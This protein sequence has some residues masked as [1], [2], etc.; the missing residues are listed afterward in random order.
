ME[1]LTKDAPL[2]AVPPARWHRQMTEEEGLHE[3]SIL[4]KRSRE[5]LQQLWAN[6]IGKPAAPGLRRE[7]LVRILEYKIREQVY[8]GLRPHIRARLREI[9]E[10]L[11]KEKPIKVA[12][13]RF[14][15]GTRLLRFQLSASSD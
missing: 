13:E 7:L 6:H 9:A 1:E 3:V 15:P 11:E 4:P 5:E 12:S 10:S 8:G 2:I 14:N